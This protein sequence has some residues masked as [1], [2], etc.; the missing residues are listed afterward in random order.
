MRHA[1]TEIFPLMWA[2]PVPRNKTH[3][4]FLKNGQYWKGLKSTSL[5]YAL[6]SESG[7]MLTHRKNSIPGCDPRTTDSRDVHEAPLEPFRREGLSKFEYH[8]WDYMGL[9]FAQNYY[10]NSFV[11][12][13]KN[14]KHYFFFKYRWHQ[15]AVTVVVPLTEEIGGLWFRTWLL[16]RCMIVIFF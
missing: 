3:I 1:H 4:F 13:V 6:L 15:P 7:R 5:L 8:S 14:R 16:Q 12:L 2:V 11:P 9:P 10:P